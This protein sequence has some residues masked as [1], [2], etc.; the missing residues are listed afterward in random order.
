M[1]KRIG[2][3]VLVAI[4]VATGVA[5]VVLAQEPTPP[6]DDV[7]PFDGPPAGDGFRKGGPHGMRGGRPQALADAL[8]ITLDDVH[9]ALAGTIADLAEGQGMTL[10]DIVDTLIEPTI[11]R[12]EQAVEDGRLTQDEADEQI[13][14]MEERL[15][16]GLETGSWFSMGHGGSRGPGDAGFHGSGDA[17][18]ELLADALG[19]TAEDVR[20]ALADGQTIAEMAEAQGV[21]LEDLVDAL[22]DPTIE[23]LEQ[24]V[25]DGRLTQDEADEQIEQMA[26]RLLEGLES[27]TGFG[28]GMMRGGFGGR[29][30]GMRD[31]P[32]P[33]TE[34]TAALT[35]EL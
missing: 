2:I 1:L 7:A 25:E 26:E 8:G 33:E 15:L 27:G 23:R 32:S 35:T 30:G 18:P 3:G 6:S 14:Q 9:A 24:A 19:M 10:A 11:E 28:R 4:V 20:E 5:G 21:A 31:R 29:P 34:D 16:E 17:Q 12:L 13:E 22:M